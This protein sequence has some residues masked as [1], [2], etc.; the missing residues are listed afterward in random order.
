MCHNF[1]SYNP[2][3]F[4]LSI[5]R[6][7]IPP[8]IKS[9][10]R[11]YILILLVHTYHALSGVVLLTIYRRSLELD[12]SLLPVFIFP[13]TVPNHRC[14]R[15]NSPPS[16]RVKHMFSQPH[17]TEAILLIPEENRADSL[18]DNIGT[19]FAFALVYIR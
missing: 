10:E 4:L 5:R 7:S 13:N 3:D 11:F 16:D 14:N 6:D 1:C 15:H 2:L 9:V 18:D 19:A 12:R 8:G 17:S